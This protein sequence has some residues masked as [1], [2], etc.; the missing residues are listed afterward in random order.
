MANY[1]LTYDSQLKGWVSFYS[2]FPEKIIGM[3]NFLYTF[4]QGNLWQHNVNNDRN[5]FYGGFNATTDSSYVTS[6]VNSSPLVN[7][8]FKAFYLESDDS[9]KATF[10]TDKITGFIDKATFERKESDW[11]AFIRTDKLP[12]TT[13]TSYDP[14][15]DLQLR[16]VNGIGQ[17]TGNSTGSPIATLQFGAAVNLNPVFIQPRDSSTLQG[18]DLLYYFAPTAPPTPPTAS[19]AIPIGIVVTVNNATK[20]ITVDTTAYSPTLPIPLGSLVISVKNST[21]ESTGLLGHYLEFTL[22]NDTQ[23]P[24][25]LF[26]IGV[27][28]MVSE[29]SPQQK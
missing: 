26:A 3:N 10:I 20:Q 16:S 5:T 21:A 25:E 14:N 11:F 12:S 19:V 1:T 4:Y 28:S 2:F 9:W 18:G 6:V 22:T 13:G 17:T 24:V 8:V 23:L 29:P 7:K 15:P 27:D